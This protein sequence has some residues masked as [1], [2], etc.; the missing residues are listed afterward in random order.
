M[1]KMI[2]IAG[3]L[4]LSTALFFTSCSSDDPAPNQPPTIGFVAGADYISSDATLTVNAPF[5]IKVT[6]EENAES[7]SNIRSLKITRVFSLSAWDT[8]FSFND[9]I[10]NAEFTF[11]AQPTAG[12]ESIEFEAVDNDGQK[13]SV[14]LKITTEEATGGPI[15]TFTMKILGSYLS[16]TGSSFASID[17]TVYTLAEAKA[18][19][20]KVDFLYWWGASSSATLGAPDDGNAALVYN[21]ATNGIPTWATKNST[22]FKTTTTTAAEFDSFMDDTD[23]ITI[24]TGSD[25]TRIGQLAVGNV[26]AF[27]TVTGKYGIIKVTEI[28]AGADG[29]ITIDVKVQQ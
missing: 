22:R 14:S 10:V 24:A 28:V 15:N 2:L 7:K 3:A 27:K 29:Q 17:G 6:I 16:A 21:N 26:I 5:K 19:S 18:N 23:I 20:T 11:N 8:T 1:K 4:L 12:Q 25:Q 13:A 9:P